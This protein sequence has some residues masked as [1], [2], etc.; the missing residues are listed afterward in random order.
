MK[1]QKNKYMIFLII[2]YF[3]LFYNIYCDDINCSG[4]SISSDNICQ[5]STNC[6]INCKNSLLLTNSVCYYCAFNSNNIFY[7]I[8]ESGC[9]VKPNCIE[10]EKLI[11]GTNECV[12]SCG[13]NLYE[14][15]S[16]CYKEQPQYTKIIDSLKKLE[17]E[18]KYY[19][20]IHDNLRKYNCLSTTSDCPDEYYA[21]FIE[22]N[23]C[24]KGDC[25]SLEKSEIKTKIIKIS[26]NKNKYECSLTCK[27]ND[28]I[29]EEEGS[30][31]CVESCKNLLKYEGPAGKKCI[32][33]D[34]C[35]SLDFKKNNDE[36]ISDCG[37][38]FYYDST[39]ETSCGAGHEKHNIGE[40]E[41]IPNCIEPYQY[42]GADNTCYNN[43]PSTFIDEDGRNCIELG[44]TNNCY[45]INNETPNKICYNECPDGFFHNNDDKIC[46]P[47]CSSDGSSKKAFKS[48][49]N[50]CYE[51]CLEIFGSNSYFFAYLNNGDIKCYS[52]K[53]KCINDGYKYLKDN[54][55]LVECPN[56]KV[57]YDSVSGNIIN[58][59]KCY[60]SISDCKT[61]EYYFYN[62]N[63]KEC[64]Y[65]SC[66]S[67][68]KTNELDNLG[69]PKEN[70][71]Y[72]TCV[73]N[74]AS[75]YLKLS[76]NIC[77]ESCSPN[78]YFDPNSSENNKCIESCGDKK[79]GPDNQCML[80]CPYNYYYIN[81]N[82]QKECITTSNCTDINK[83]Y[84]EGDFQCYEECKKVIDGKIKYYFYNSDNKC[85]ETC[86]GNTDDGEYGEEPKT[87]SKKCQ[88]LPADKYFYQ[89]DHIIRDSCDIFK[90]NTSQECVKQCSTV[91]KDKVCTDSCPY[92]FVE[93]QYSILGEIQPNTIKKC[94]SNCKDESIKYKFIRVN[95]NQCLENCPGDTYEI[96]EYCYE[97]DCYL[98][99]KKY[100]NPTTNTCEE[101]CGTLLYYEKI[102][103]NYDIYLCKN[104][105]N[106]NKPYKLGNDYK[107]CLS[108]CPN[109]HNYIGNDNECLTSCGDQLTII[110]EDKSFYSL[111]KCIDICPDNGYYSE[112]EFVCYDICLKSKNNHQFSLT[113]KEDGQIKRKCE[114]GCS[115]GIGP[116]EYIYYK[117]TN[118]IC[119]KECD[120]IID[121]D[122]HKCVEKCNDP[123]YLFEF[124]NKCLSECPDNYLRYS[125]NNYK[126]KEKCEKPNHYVYNNICLS[127]CEPGQYKKKV[128]KDD[129]S[130]ILWTEEYECVPTNENKYYYESDK[131][132]LDSCLNND[133]VIQG[134]YQCVNNCDSLSGNY[135][136]YEVPASGDKTYMVNTCVFACPNEK[137]FLLETNHCSE[138]CISNNKF[139]LELEK[140]CLEVCP[141]NYYYTLNGLCLEK[142]EGE[143][144]FLDN[145][146]CVEYCPNER[147]Y[148]IGSYNHEEENQQKKCLSD[149]TNQYQYYIEKQITTTQKNYECQESCPNSN[150]YIVTDKIAKLCIV[151]DV[152]TT[153][154]CPNDFPFISENG[155]E[156][157]SQCP[158]G[159]FYINPNKYSSYNGLFLKKCLSECPPDYPFHEV[160]SY[161]CI[162]PQDCN[163]KIADYES[164][165]CVIKCSTKYQSEVTED[166][167]IGII[168]LN[169]C[170]EK[171]GK[172]L[173]PDKK[174]VANCADYNSIVD[175][176]NDI[177]G[178]CK[179]KKLY[180]YDDS[181]IM[182]CYDDSKLEC[183]SST[184]P[185]IIRKYG[186]DQ[187]IKIC[188]GI[189]S[190]DE[191]IC[192]DNTHICNQNT[193]LITKIN[194]QKKCECMYKYYYN[195]NKKKCLGQNEQCPRNLFIPET[196]GCV[197]ECEGD[198]SKK[199]YNFC[200]S[201]CPDGATD[202]SNI[203]TCPKKWYSISNEFICYDS[204][205]CP[206]SYPLEDISTHQCLKECR[207]ISNYILV[208]DKCVND[209]SGYTGTSLQTIDY[210][211]DDYKFADY[212]C[213]CNNKWYY[214]ISRNE[215]I[216]LESHTECSDI[217]PNLKYIIKN[218]KQCVSSCP[219]DYSYSFNDEC[220]HS[221]EEFEEIY[222][223]MSALNSKI[224]K[225]KNLWKYIEN[226]KIECIRED[227][228]PREYVQIY[229]KK[230]CL[231]GNAC[232]RES[233]LIFNRICYNKNNCP[234]NSHFDNHYEGKCIC[235]NLWYQ[236]TDININIDFQFCLPKDVNRC[237]MHSSSK[238]PYQIYST[239]ECLEQGLIC[240]ENSYIFNYICYENN[241][242]INTIEKTDAFDSVNNIHY[243]ICDTNAGYWYE[244][245]FD[246]TNR[247]YLK[248][249]LQKCEGEYI[250]LYI[251][252]NECLKDC[253][254]KTGEETHEP[255]FSFRGICY[256]EC[257]MFTK[258]NYSVFK[259]DFYSLNEAQNLTQL[260]DYTNIQV[261]ELYQI[262][263]AGGYLFNRTEACIQIYGIDKNNNI[264]NKHLIMKSN[265]AYIDLDTCTEKIFI[266]NNLSDD[267]KILVIKYDMLSF[268]IKQNSANE[269]LNTDI[270]FDNDYYLINPVEYEF[271]SS[272][273]G[274]NIDASI[275][276][277]NEII[278]SYPISYTI[279]KY[280]TPSNWTKINEYK[281]KFDMGKELSHKNKNIDIFN[282]NN[283]VYK[284]VCVGVEL[285]G[286]DLILEDRYDYLYPNNI[287][288]CENNCTFYS[289]DYE[290][291]RIACKCNYKKEIDFNREYPETSDLLN[292]PN[293]IYPKQS[294]AS[295]EVIK[296]LSKFPSKDSIIKNEAFYYC[297]V[298]TVAEI[299]MIFVAAFH[300]LKAV[301]ANISSLMNKPNIKMDIGNKNKVPK[302]NLKTENNIISTSQR[303]LNNPPRK[304]NNKTNDDEEEEK[305][306]YI[307]NI[308]NKNNILI[309]NNYSKNKN[310]IDI[311]N[312]SENN[313]SDESES[314]N[315]NFGIAIKDA[316]KSIIIKNNNN[317][318]DNQNNNNDYIG[319][320][321]FM[322][323]KYNFK[324]FKSND[325]GVIKKIERNK[326][327]FK[328]KP[329]TKYL[330]ERKEGINYDPNYLNGPFFTNQNIIEIIDEEKVVKFENSNHNIN[331]IINKDKNNNDKNNNNNLGESENKNLKK[332]NLKNNKDIN[333]END[334]ITIKKI[335]P[336]K[337]KDDVQFTVENYKKEEKD[338]YDN[339][340][341]YTL[342]KR[343]HSLLRASFKSYIGKLHSSLLSIFL[344]EIM[345]KIYILKIC[346]FLKKYEMFSVHLVLYLICHLMLL[347]LLCSFFTIKVI[348]Q[349][350][351]EDNFPQISF[352]LL[353]GFLG[354][355]II[356][357]IYKIFL[358]LLDSQDKV[359][360]LIQL[361]NSL[362]KENK[363]NNNIDGMT[364]HDEDINEDLIQKK[365]NDLI[366]RIKITMIIF[367]VIS[368]LLTVF[369]F[370]YLLSFFAIYTGTKSRVIKMYF[371]SLIEILLIKIVYGIILAS[372]RIASEGN[373]IEKIYK[374]VY[375]CDKFAS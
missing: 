129:G 50:I 40:L 152:S 251:K 346:C 343:E 265:L 339:T 285:K 234:E 173:T 255:M 298:V 264:N 235:D 143:T 107:E 250:N 171:Y 227:F 181:N 209:C 133:Y 120:Q 315:Q 228:C 166:S 321:E 55:C 236:Y 178:V 306:E 179:C 365:Y 349:I 224:C 93:V 275:C 126:C 150:V 13:H 43:C 276:E 333:D 345:D 168:C 33:F 2:I 28:Y 212:T 297:T 95:T 116:D 194:G 282:F 46:K 164:G 96:G 341:L 283:S 76:G 267:D 281:R 144:P 49:S 39:C 323:M 361:K 299:S 80:D 311:E 157:Y 239:K 207:E 148:Y 203:C 71:E 245:L 118:K 78:E 119:L 191:D 225:C 25:T 9:S 24:F 193:H 331:N 60:D 155:R 348:K 230:Q 23:L 36:C 117:E 350:W 374:I 308:I 359:K 22:E 3:Y 63:M 300:G 274:E 114:E 325:K 14:L 73:Y 64:W 113:Y 200:L 317:L 66:P 131:I 52:D 362:N 220:L 373:E 249:G 243:C 85:L 29:K 162:K 295:G 4:C 354:N 319:K 147:K 287:T 141:R 45:Y 198:Y 89:S 35:K 121:Y 332:R 169:E 208:I 47:K 21:L 41:C 364:E 216:C 51:N 139:Y 91:V 110:Y 204:N 338:I 125:T 272:V 105:C 271:F 342:I 246:E 53:T 310:N 11:D 163:S 188:G 103:E 252:G 294:G 122:G 266:D 97:K 309:N 161:E 372:L 175:L 318:I 109:G 127:G 280:D 135:H 57:K 136:Y 347:T 115:N 218:T 293:F 142:C 145:N 167:N 263:N 270:I 177:S 366:K 202:I 8:R 278:V 99:N 258:K 210:Y 221:C 371:I 352:Y 214:D 288:L 81:S 328:I 189:L 111:Y 104:Q 61:N 176:I 140:K 242:P 201:A 324:Y 72:N 100:I 247:P 65:S 259:C 26:E 292:D 184:S 74:C 233:P 77:K 130:T 153:N 303:V 112:E 42:L 32:S 213:R 226:G 327:P 277:P 222:F 159:K 291:G 75:P 16:Y 183:G 248:C 67:D 238:Y 232:P 6:D 256:E 44:Q 253:R 369:C 138:S 337:K 370:I 367:F 286:K 187:C 355:I 301:S 279:P 101:N 5:G 12:S 172:Y 18:N 322:P 128:M 62:S 302:N 206:D 174:C 195:D 284:D 83:Y 290:L 223:I 151:K 231:L 351:S 244:Y 257:P 330:L 30:K 31:Y 304:G 56:F 19:I 134:Q 79:I 106:S 84:F 38:N 180:Y 340:G 20:T 368:F 86:I 59:G 356:W 196:N 254:I 149:C 185:Y 344:A 289:T 353:Y 307:P 240:P 137:P 269:E 237:P 296:C 186:T 268:N 10:G 132:L 158:Y 197:T 15:G 217:S 241:C 363:E 190:V 314:Y 335:K 219:N 336:M 357:F 17:C 1:K 88:N 27:N 192:Y 360:E 215:N 205:K 316:G 262:S 211:A 326:I 124:N 98:S 108:E 92:Y 160:N 329:S 182:R 54:E 170:V 102:S 34:E 261:R 69:H 334:F 82:Q 312:E 320:S 358:C 229:N 154:G 156:C 70:S 305:S 94:V 165:I 48:E 313:N 68:M 123:D 90:D 58:L 199:F 7:S 273:T 146:N 375:L 87:I 260:R 37:T